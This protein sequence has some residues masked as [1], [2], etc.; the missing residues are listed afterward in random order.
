MTIDKALEVLQDILKFV[1]PGDP[2]DEHSAITLGVEALIAIKSIR[3][4]THQTL[5]QTILALIATPLPG[6]T[7]E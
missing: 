1:E 6:E 3:T 2:Q 4:L 5:D 7:K